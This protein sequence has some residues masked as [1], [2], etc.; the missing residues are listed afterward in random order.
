MNNEK[1]GAPA[2]PELTYRDYLIWTAVNTAAA[3]ARLSTKEGT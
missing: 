1:G 3:L 2:P